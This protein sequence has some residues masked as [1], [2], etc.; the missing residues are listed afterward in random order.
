MLKHLNR[1]QP[2]GPGN[3]LPIF[4][5]NYVTGTGR[6]VGKADEHLKLDIDIPPYRRSI[7]GIAFGQARLVPHVLSGRP[8]DICYAITENRYRGNI[9]LQLRIN[10]IKASE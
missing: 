8:F 10:D 3:Q 5:T 6:K 4:R 7:S 2:F 1:F 9:E